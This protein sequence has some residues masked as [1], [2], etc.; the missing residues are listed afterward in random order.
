MHTVSLVESQINPSLIIDKDSLHADLFCNWSA[1]SINGNNISLLT[2][3]RQQGGVIIAIKD[4]TS[5]FATSLVV[6]YASLGRWN[7]IGVI[8]ET[9]IARMITS[10]QKVKFK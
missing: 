10:S 1:A 6:D 5:K 4:I 9:N 3:R 2:C 8:N 7:N